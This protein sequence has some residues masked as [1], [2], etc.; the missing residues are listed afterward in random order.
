M[1]TSAQLSFLLLPNPDHRCPQSLRC[2]TLH[3]PVVVESD[4]KSIGGQIVVN[5]TVKCIPRV[6]ELRPRVSG[7]GLPVVLQLDHLIL[8]VRQAV[9][10]D[11]QLGWVNAEVVEVSEDEVG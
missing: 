11:T 4:D 7:R 8:I 5:D 1:I 3:D 2:H 6:V 10:L 9:L